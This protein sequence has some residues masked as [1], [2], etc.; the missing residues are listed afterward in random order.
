[1]Y[2]FLARAQQYKEMIRC[3]VRHNSLEL[4]A[5]QAGT[6]EG[7]LKESQVQKPRTTILALLNSNTEHVLR[8]TLLSK[9]P[10]KGPSLLR[11]HP[12]QQHPTS[13]KRGFPLQLHAGLRELHK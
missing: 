10:G 8:Q 1:M 12:N 4:I 5:V 13:G 3:Q 7:S 2:P 11:T 9:A 6:H